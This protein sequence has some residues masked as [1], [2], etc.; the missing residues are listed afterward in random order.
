MGMKLL[1]RKAVGITVGLAAGLI[2]SGCG[3]DASSG[4]SINGLDKIPSAKGI[5]SSSS[6]GSIARSAR[7]RNMSLQSTSG[8]PPL[9]VDLS[10]SNVDQYFFNGVVG[11]INGGSWGG[12]TSGAKTELANN[13][14]GSVDGG[15]GGNGACMMAQ[16]VGESI[17]RMLESATSLCYMK[18]IPN[19]SGVTITPSIEGS[20]LFQQQA[21]DRI[22]QVNVSGGDQSQKIF[23][24]VAGTSTVGADVYKVQLGMC[25]T[26]G[27]ARGLETIEVNRTTGRMTATGLHNEGSGTGSNS[28][29]GGLRLAADGNLEWDPTSVRTATGAW[30]GDWGT[31]KGSLEIS[32]A[33]VITAKRFNVWDQ[34]GHDGVDKNYSI[35]SFSGTSLASVRFLEAA[36]KGVNSFDD[37]EHSYVG[38]TSYRD[39]FYMN[40]AND[41]TSTVNAYDIDGDS[42][43]ANDVSEPDLSVVDCG[44]TPEYT[45]TVDMSSGP[46]EAVRATCEGDRYDNYDLCRSDAIQSAQNRIFTHYMTP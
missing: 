41:F 27:A 14:W 33:G 31:F 16:S 11:T 8:T 26:E 18:N 28:M 7:G 38:S 21:A 4:L 45:V 13:F 2:A 20:A 43:F 23:I 22:V 30:N 36:F 40:V 46:M 37:N 25:T 29:T 42:F 39:T 17:G 24:R 3:S 15:A 35:S 34:G 6:G 5:V 32:S 12:L 44:L 1:G 10:E 9:L 19:V